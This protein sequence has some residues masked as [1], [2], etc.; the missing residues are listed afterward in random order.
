MLPHLGLHGIEIGEHPPSGRP[1]WQS[2]KCRPPAV[3]RPNRL[4]FFV[5]HASHSCKCALEEATKIGGPRWRHTDVGFGGW[6]L[7]RRNVDKA[8]RR[9]FRLAP[10]GCKDHVVGVLNL[11]GQCH[12]DFSEVGLGLKLG[13]G[14]R[15]PTIMTI[16]P[17]VLLH[18]VLLA[19][20]RVPGGR[21]A[22]ATLGRKPA[23]F[24]Q[25]GAVEAGHFAAQGPAL[26]GLT[27]YHTSRLLRE[28]LEGLPEIRQGLGQQLLHVVVAA[29]RQRGRVCLLE[30]HDG[31]G[32]RGD[33]RLGRPQ[34]RKVR[35]R[36]HARPA[37]HRLV[38]RVHMRQHLTEPMPYSA[39]AG[40][41]TIL[42][43]SG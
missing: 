22:R 33:A 19:R 13:L 12:P 25:A 40:K 27:R 8:F 16:R 43:Q 34:L 6:L 9:R 17:H 3:V 1:G 30:L 23:E 20:Q 14:P 35:V 41:A 15:L 29:R 42:T 21:H 18:A 4:L 28:A 7:K 26:R 37:Q 5:V 32:P 2:S 11:V 10:A 39:A 38:G 31:P 36:A 24:L